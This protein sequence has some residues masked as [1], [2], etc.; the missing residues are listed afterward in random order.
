MGCRCSAGLRLDP[1]SVA[2]WLWGGWAA[3]GVEESALQP[4]VCAHEISDAFA[5]LPTAACLCSLRLSLTES[6]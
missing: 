4:A 6:G 2:L 1:L 3:A 5:T